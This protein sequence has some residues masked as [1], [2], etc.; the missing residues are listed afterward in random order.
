MEAIVPRKDKEEEVM[1]ML[2]TIVSFIALGTAVGM[3]IAAL[4]VIKY[5]K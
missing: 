4:I 1:E 2:A 3:C 5:L